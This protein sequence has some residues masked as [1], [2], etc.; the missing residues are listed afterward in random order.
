[1]CNVATEDL[2][3]WAE[4]IRFPGE[5]DTEMVK[6]FIVECAI[7]GDVLLSCDLS[8]L[9]AGLRSVREKSESGPEYRPGQAHEVCPKSSPYPNTQ[10]L[11]LEP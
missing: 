2:A 8:T 1:M 10:T 7:D 11:R 4:Y 9:V 6:K 5:G 3:K